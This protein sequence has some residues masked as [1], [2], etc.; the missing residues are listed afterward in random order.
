MQLLTEGASRLPGR[1]GALKT[2]HHGV[3]LTRANGQKS[4]QIG[5]FCVRT[6]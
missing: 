1:Y 2:A 4:S 6:S 5:G 3:K